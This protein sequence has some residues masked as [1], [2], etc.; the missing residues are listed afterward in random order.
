MN[1]LVKGKLGAAKPQPKPVDVKLV[2]ELK[3]EEGFS[4]TPYVDTTGHETIGYGH[5]QVP[6]T[7]AEHFAYLTETQGEAVLANDLQ[8]TVAEL[9]SALL[10]W[11]QLD[12]VRQRAL[13]DMAFNLGVTGLCGFHRMLA[14]LAAGDWN[15]AAA[16]GQLSV[17]YTQ[18]GE[19]AHRILRM[20]QTGV[21][22]GPL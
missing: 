16:N 20:L 7:G 1:D 2:A 17:W 4:Q 21:D 5:N 22:S 3:I 10:W 19:R 15:G 9:D 8:R 14:C 13:A 11:R 6:C 12:E 18:T